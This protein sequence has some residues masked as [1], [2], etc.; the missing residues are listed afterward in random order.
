MSTNINVR[1]RTNIAISTGIVNEKWQS[2]VGPSTIVKHPRKLVWDQEVESSNLSAPIRLFAYKKGLFGDRADS[3]AGN[4]TARRYPGA[5]A[6]PVSPVGG[7][8]PPARGR[9]AP[10]AGCL[11]KTIRP[12]IRAHGRNWKSGRLP[13][14]VSPARA[15]SGENQG[16]PSA[17]I[18]ARFGRGVGAIARAT[19]CGRPHAPRLA[20][21][22]GFEKFENSP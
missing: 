21:L 17:G 1:Q 9:A 3:R 7:S 13:G 6:G 19:D 8:G 11:A 20:F 18:A 4:K 12:A 2:A 15:V 22:S 5:T 14:A 16:F 10:P